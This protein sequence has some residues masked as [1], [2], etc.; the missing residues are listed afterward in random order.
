MKETHALECIEF[1][2]QMMKIRAEEPAIIFFCSVFSREVIAAFGEFIKDPT[3]SLFCIT[4]AIEKP[5]F[6][7]AWGEKAD[8]VLGT[9]PGF[10]FH[11]SEYT[12]ENPEY[13]VHYEKG[14]A[15][16][17]EFVKRYGERAMFSAPCAADS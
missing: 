7:G 5:E 1:G 17:A 11:T 12:G 6:R 14:E 8:G 4:W 9:L 13:I 16:H 15:I 10:F 3:N 2:P